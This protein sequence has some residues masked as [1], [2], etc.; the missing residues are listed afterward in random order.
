MLINNKNGFTFIELLCSVVMLSVFMLIALPNV[1]KLVNSGEK[2]IYTL[3]EEMIVKAAEMYKTNCAVKNECV[4]TETAYKSIIN[5][6]D[7][8]KY[9]YISPIKLN[10]KNC[11]GKVEIQNGKYKVKLEC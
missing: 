8:V 2:E 9:N 6:D 4:F 1:I 5:I 3:Q 7:L 11:S 10:N